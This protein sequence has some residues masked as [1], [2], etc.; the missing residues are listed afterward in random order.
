MAWSNDDPVST[1]DAAAP[2]TAPGTGG[3]RGA[4]FR[5]GLFTTFGVLLAVGVA[6]VVREVA[7]V[8]E[9]VLV[10]GLPR[11]GSTRSSSS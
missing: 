3:D 4:A 10:S 9:L 5:R 6:L 7:S 1:G 11:S 8:V 2:V